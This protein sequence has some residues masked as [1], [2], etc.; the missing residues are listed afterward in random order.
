MAKASRRRLSRA[1]QRSH[2]AK[3]G[4]IHPESW[5]KD[6]LAAE[7]GTIFKQ[8]STTIGLCYPNPYHTAMSS[9]GYQVV[10]R[11]MN[12]TPDLAAERIVLPPENEDG[13]QF[14]PLSLE[15]GKPLAD[16]TLLA[17]SIAYD[18]DISGFFSIL[19]GGGVP[20]LRDDRKET[21][22]PIMLGGPLTASNALPFGPFIDLAVIGD[23]EDALKKLLPLI[24]QARDR[25]QLL[26]TAANIPGVWV[27][28]IHG[29]HV[30]PTQKVTGAHAL[31]AIS[32]IVT[33][34][35]ELSNM[36]LVEASRG[37]PRYCKF[38]LVRAP[39]SPMRQSV[40]DTV[41]ERIPEDAPRVGFVGAAISE[42][43]GIREALARTIEKGKGVGISSLRADRLDKE[44]V[45]LLAAGGY[46]TLTVAGDAPSQRLRNSLAKGIRTRHLVR[47]AQLAS[48]AGMRKMKLYTILGLPTESDD[49]IDELVEL[50]QELSS[51]LPVALGIAPLVP[52]LHTPLGN[53]PFAGIKTVRARLKYLR[54]KLPSRVEI[55]STSA[56]WAW[57]EF[58]L[59]QGDATAGLAAL[60]A[61]QRGGRFADYKRAFAEVEE[62]AGL[63]AAE[64][65]G[66]WLAAGMK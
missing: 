13:A 51:Y 36:F 57:V 18:L 23:G 20:I 6:L 50:S 16:F 14:K 22:P 66:L 26:E 24:P 17:F 29:D 48:E 46:R 10:Y 4:K 53:A 37:C 2:R 7:K 45:G 27:P 58:R 61:W 28:Q 52:K 5:R 34:H 54:E 11:M 8:A 41:I 39:E 1:E 21:D 62:R 65:A 64:R 63:H 32:Q 25:R 12:D 60:K 59:S 31:P 33:P 56:K 40:V 19:S 44:F 55:R 43:E 9:L 42:W 49:D 38:C 30:P 15:S 35:T 3:S 47:S